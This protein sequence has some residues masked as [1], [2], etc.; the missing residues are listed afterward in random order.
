MNNCLITDTYFLR[1]KESLLMRRTYNSRE[2]KPTLLE[3]LL[4]E[5]VEEKVQKAT[6]LIRPSIYYLIHFYKGLR[7]NCSAEAGDIFL[8][9]KTCFY[10]KLCATHSYYLSF[11]A[12]GTNADIGI[13]LS[14]DSANAVPH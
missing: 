6:C 5:F 2:H 1:A 3:S 14:G 10:L 13:I 11:Q 7:L 12:R 8:H 9:C 4:Q